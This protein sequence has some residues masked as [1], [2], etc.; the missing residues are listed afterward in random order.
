V[1]PFTDV[2][3][4]NPFYVYIKCLYCRGI[5]SG[6]SDNTFRPYDNITRG[7][8]SKIVSNAAGFNDPVSGQTYTDVP[9]SHPFYV[10]I[11]R[12]TVRNIATGYNTAAECP[13]GAPC[14]R[15]E[16]TLT[17]GQMA[18]IDSNAA[19]F[20]D[21]PPAGTLTFT[22]VPPSH[23]FYIYI[24]RLSRRGIVG[25]YEC[26]IDPG[27]PCDGGNRPY[28][29]PENNVTRGQSAK[30]VSNTFFAVDCTPGIPPVLP[31]R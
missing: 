7:Q 6:Y 18:K 27:E 24:E 28:Y 4:Y 22:D 30:I 3:E 31:G 1:L 19:G 17:R 14:F 11:E 5:V 9:P 20:T 12:L 23:P 13:T 10:W 26:G 21:V 2:D 15:P 29:R 25:G 16:N 8:M